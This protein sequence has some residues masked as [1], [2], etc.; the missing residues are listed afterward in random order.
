[1]RLP[2][3][4]EIS[5]HDRAHFLA[6]AARTMR[7]VLVD[8]ARGRHADKRG[9][10]C[11]QVTLEEAKSQR[12]PQTVDM[13][14]LDVALTRLAAVD[15]LQTQVVE[16]RYFGGLTIEE[17]AATLSMAPATVKRKWTMARAWL[18]RALQG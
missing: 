10:D 17:I 5:C 7:R 12:A 4:Q 14:D 8:H 9:G 15:A 11:V 3:L 2:A 6:L 13:V 18:C 16:L 1:M